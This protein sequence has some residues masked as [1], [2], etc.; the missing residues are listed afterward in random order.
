MSVPKSP[1][2]PAHSIRAKRLPRKSGR[3]DLRSRASGAGKS[4]DVGGL[5]IVHRY[6]VLTRLI[7]AANSRPWIRILPQ[8]PCNQDPADIPASESPRQGL[9]CLALQTF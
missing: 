4:S 7:V 5:V 9:Q 1:N 2:A 3:T 6:L 8:A